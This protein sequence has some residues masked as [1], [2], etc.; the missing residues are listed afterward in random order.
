MG[1]FETQET[2]TNRENPNEPK[3]GD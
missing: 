1:Y 2:Q 3:K